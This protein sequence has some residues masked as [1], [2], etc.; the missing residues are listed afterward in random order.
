M[1]AKF[2]LLLLED[3]YLQRTD[4]RKTL[5]ERFDV[6]VNAKSTESEFVR[7]FEQIATNP[8]HAAIL[9]VMVRWTNPSR[10]AGP[11]PEN[12]IHPEI[13][14]LRCAERLRN[15]PR[16][17]RVN[18]ILYSVLGPEDRE[19]A[20]IPDGVVS[21]VKE[22]DFENLFEILRLLALPIKPPS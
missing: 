12:A 15:D 17:Q 16:T 8:P 4:I 5:E 7:D 2:K 3:D 20:P 14:G 13:A 19:D 10:D 18:V 1:P 22:S 11:E 9:D 21:V 6:E